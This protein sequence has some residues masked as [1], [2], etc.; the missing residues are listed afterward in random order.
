MAKIEFTVTA[1]EKERIDEFVRDNNYSSRAQMLHKAVDNFM[2]TSED[3]ETSEQTFEEYCA[4]KEEP[5]FLNVDG[6]EVEIVR[7][8]DMVTCSGTNDLT[9]DQMSRLGALLKEYVC[10]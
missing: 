3:T 4:R 10:P 8:G 1:E 2:N 7:M 6:V 5:R 9:P